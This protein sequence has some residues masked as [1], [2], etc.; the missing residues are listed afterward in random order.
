MGNNIYEESPI[1]EKLFID[2]KSFIISVKAGDLHV[3]GNRWEWH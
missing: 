2:Y 3:V 1:E